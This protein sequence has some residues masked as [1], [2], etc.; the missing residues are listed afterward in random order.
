MTKETIV[1]QTRYSIPDSRGVQLAPGEI[2]TVEVDEAMQRHIDEGDVTVI[3]RV[4][5][6][7]EG[8]PSSD[9]RKPRATARQ[10]SQEN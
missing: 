4:E 6:V 9:T 1:V 2:A 8:S 10:D 5:K 3:P 7:V